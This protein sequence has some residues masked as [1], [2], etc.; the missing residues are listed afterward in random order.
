MYFI[1]SVTS[2]Y[3]LA[4]QSIYPFPLLPLPVV[5]LNT[6]VMHAMNLRG[7]GGNIYKFI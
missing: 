7:P 1:Q 4:E 6:L 3:H 5:Y 2:A